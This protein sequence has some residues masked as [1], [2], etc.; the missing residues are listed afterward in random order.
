VNS[1]FCENVKIY[2]N[3]VENACERLINHINSEYN[4]NINNKLDLYK[5]IHNN[6]IYEYKVD[7]DKYYF[8]GVGCSVERNNEIAIDWNFGYRNWWCGIDPNKMSITLKNASECTN[9]YIEM[10]KIKEECT[11]M[12][13]EK[14]MLFY[15]NQYYFDL[16]KLQTKTQIIPEEYD[17]ISITYNGK[18]II[19]DKSKV[20]DKFIRK[21]RVVYA[22]IE[23]LKNNYTIDFYKDDNII[24]SILYNDNA[25]SDKAVMIMNNELLKPYGIYIWSII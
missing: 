7:N 1:L 3:I 24:F 17:K 21:S 12:L 16:M 8:H 20:V 19:I 23:H 10:N 14:K 11:R 13:E 15:K 22:N 2:Y 18:S 6:R 25:Y 4:A 9:S 5:F